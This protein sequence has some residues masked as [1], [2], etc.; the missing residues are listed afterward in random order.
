MCKNGTLCALACALAL[1]RAAAADF[2]SVRTCEID[3][4]TAYAGDAALYFDFAAEPRGASVAR[5]A[6]GQ[7]HDGVAEGCAWCAEGRFAGGALAFSGNASSVTV[8]GA[9]DF[10][11]WDAY[12]ASVWFLHDGGGERGPQYGHKILDRTSPDHD[13]H[14]SLRPEGHAA[15]TGAVGLSLYESGRRLRLED[16]SRNWA[17]GDWHH[18]VV[19]RNGR[20]GELWIDGVRR[21]ASENMFAVH[22]AGPFCIG[23]SRSADRHQRTG[24]SGRLDEV[25]VFARALTQEEVARL[26][27]VGA[28]GTGD[29]RVT[30]ASDVEFAGGVSVAGPAVFAEG[31]RYVRPRGDLALGSETDGRVSHAE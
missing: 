29:G 17:D 16:A 4:G 19:I 2:D 11:S 5:D 25:R 22:G 13:W 26:Y 1:G 12:S 3:A 24:W 28:A 6:G 9:P 31:I 21:A 10:P 14:L 18:A 27:T 20:H 7:A 30:F 8:P 23:N 15:D